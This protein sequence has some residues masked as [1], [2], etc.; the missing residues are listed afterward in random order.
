MVCE[1]VDERERERESINDYLSRSV[2][3]LKGIRQTRWSFFR[4]S[5]E[6]LPLRKTQ[7]SLKRFYLLSVDAYGP[8]VPPA[9]CQTLR[10]L[11]RPQKLW[12]RKN[13]VLRK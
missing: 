10:L 8:L 6:P 12:T 5:C 2:I 9:V 7:E 1:G 4:R 11:L 13:P 3:V